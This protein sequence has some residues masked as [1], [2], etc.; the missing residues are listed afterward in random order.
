[1]FGSTLTS[2][3]GA[4]AGTAVHMPPLELINSPCW[5]PAASTY[6]PAAVQA[7]VARQVTASSTASWPAMGA[8]AGNGAWVGS[9]QWP[10]V[11]VKIKPSQTSASVS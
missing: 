4:G 8:P 3:G 5:C 10:S 1:M 2:F 9:D 7:P 11:S 6:L